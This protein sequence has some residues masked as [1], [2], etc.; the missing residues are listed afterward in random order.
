MSRI[1]ICIL[2]SWLALGLAPNLVQ[3]TSVNH[4][5]KTPGYHQTNDGAL[6]YA[7]GNYF[8]AYR[9]FKSAARWSDKTA[10]FNLGVMYYLG[11]HVERNIPQAW[12]WFKLSAERGYPLMVEATESIGSE[13]TPEQQAL[14]EGLF[15]NLNSKYGDDATL[16]RTQRRMDRDRRS[17]GGSRVG[18]PMGPLL[19]LEPG[20]QGRNNGYG[21][22]A[23]YFGEVR[24]GHQDY[25]DR[26]RWDLD[27]VLAKEADFWDAMAR[28][29]VTL[30]DF[31]V[32]EE[33]AK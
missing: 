33:D 29:N 12:A 22:T 23:V 5:Q 13:M 16:S 15:E 21:Q 2:L 14:A 31:I 10:Q 7:R 19:T 26:E 11:H 24:D 28:S 27:W 25:Y 32:Q 17:L 6:E 4:A 20:G 9:D 30:R 18:T 3:A 8:D 1:K